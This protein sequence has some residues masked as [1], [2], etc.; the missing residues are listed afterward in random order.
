MLQIF[1]CETTLDFRDCFRWCTFP[2]PRQH[3]ENSIHEVPRRFCICQCSL[4][5]HKLLPQFRG[6]AQPRALPIECYLVPKEAH[7]GR[8]MCNQD[9]SWGSS[10]SISSQ[11]WWSL[12]VQTKK[13][14]DRSS[15]RS[16]EC[17]SWL[18]RQTAIAVLSFWDFP[19]RLDFHQSLVDF[20]SHR[21]HA[22]FLPLLHQAFLPLT[23]VFAQC[24]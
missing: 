8:S 14:A 16:V 11:S 9:R 7:W 24:Q 20:Q 6:V 22:V 5:T 2:M 19:W 21:P 4:L 13:R 17:K 10:P 1:R 15:R 12:L 3:R 23:L 18:S